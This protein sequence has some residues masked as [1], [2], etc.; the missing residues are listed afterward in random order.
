MDGVE[1][2]KDHYGPLHVSHVCVWQPSAQLFCVSQISGL[3]LTHWQVSSPQA[4][5]QVAAVGPGQAWQVA[6]LAQVSHVPQAV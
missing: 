4:V 6:W 5:R 1:C 2:L 3:L